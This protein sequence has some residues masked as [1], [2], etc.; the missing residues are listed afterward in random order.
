MF[1]LVCRSQSIFSQGRLATGAIFS[2]RTVGSWLKSLDRVHRIFVTKFCGKER[3]FP[4]NQ[5]RD[6]VIRS[7]LC[8]CL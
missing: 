6:E 7:R 1:S 2:E 8:D 4:R 5:T 3:I